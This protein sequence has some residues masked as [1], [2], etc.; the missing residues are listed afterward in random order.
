MTSPGMA[1]L[2]LPG[3]PQQ[4]YPAGDYCCHLFTRSIDSATTPILMSDIK[5]QLVTRDVPSRTKVGF[6][7]SSRK[8]FLFLFSR[9]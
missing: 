4:K 5:E 1:K 8:I 2:A 6:P 7:P 3:M 9:S